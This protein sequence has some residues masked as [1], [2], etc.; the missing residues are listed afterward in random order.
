MMKKLREEL[1]KLSTEIITAKEDVELVELYNKARIIYEKLAVLKFIE[2]KLN[3]VQVDVSKNVV[4]S[5]FEKVANAVLSGNTSVPESNPHEED[6][7]TPGMDTIKDIVS[8]M[9]TEMALDQIFAEFVAKPDL[10]KNDKEN[11]APLKEDIKQG[12]ANLPKSLNDKLGKDFQIG[13]NDKLA[14]VKHLFNNSMEDYTR[15][16]SQLNTID[17]EERSIA[18]INNMVKPEYN[19]WEGKEE[20]ETRLITLIERRFA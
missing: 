19:N 13:L 20:Y 10:M 2:E 14:F 8:E 1:I 11:L 5:R 12:Q 17:T 4:A 9:P 15:V 6:I 3:D 7:M 16:L 18:F